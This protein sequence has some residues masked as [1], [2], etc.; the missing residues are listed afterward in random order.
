MKELTKR[1]NEVL[2]FIKAYM[3]ENQYPPTVRE[4]AADFDISVRAAFDHLRALQKKHAISTDL[5][6]SRSIRIEEPDD[7][8]DRYEDEREEIIE[9]PLLGNVAAGQPLI[10]E[11]NFERVLKIPASSLPAGTYFALRVKG[12]S[13]LHAGI[14]D[15]DTAII[16]QG[17]TAG[18]GDIVVAR[19]NDDAVTLKRFF[20]ETNRI[21]LK[22][23]N[24]VYP[25][26][27]SQNARILGKL[28]FIIRDYT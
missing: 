15:G 7:A 19:I 12:D 5:N 4:I 28:C 8:D 13:M 24:P 18:N 3:E 27:Y 9:V 2:E 1:Q 10:A 26:I 14:L 21:K 16:R 6:R 22:A 17:E 20:R 25:P 23:E 11:E